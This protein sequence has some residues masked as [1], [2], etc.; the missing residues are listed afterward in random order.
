MVPDI[1]RSFPLGGKNCL[2]SGRRGGRRAVRFPPVEIRRLS[3]D[4]AAEYRA[5]RIAAATESPHAFGDTPEGMASRPA[6]SWRSLLD[7]HRDPDGLA[8]A[9]I[10]GGRWIGSMRA[11][12]EDGVAWIYS[13]Y[14]APDARRAGVASELMTELLA[15]SAQY[16]PAAMLHV[17]EVNE[18]ARRLYERFGF[19]PTGVTVQN[20]AYPANTELEMRS[21]LD[22]WRSFLL[23]GKHLYGSVPRWGGEHPERRR[24]P[25][26]RAGGGVAD[27][28]AL[29][30]HHDPRGDGVPRAGRLG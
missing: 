4:D 6:E 16:A 24:H 22:P 5:F 27:A 25:L 28:R 30:R 7:R 13:V 29:P 1:R 3:G 20:P 14:V 26:D 15:W 2:K 18:R 10:E 9:A 8:L 19:A 23:S 12:V 21:R 17:G 11:L